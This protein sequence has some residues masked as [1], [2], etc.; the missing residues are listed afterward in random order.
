M[1]AFTETEGRPDMTFRGVLVCIRTEGN[2][3][4]SPALYCTH[5]RKV[6]REG[7]GSRGTLGTGGPEGSEAEG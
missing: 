5:R 6:V 3:L 2:T 1:L 4:K 7:E